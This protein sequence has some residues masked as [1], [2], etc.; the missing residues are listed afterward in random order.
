MWVAWLLWLWV[1]RPNQYFLVSWGRHCRSS[2]AHIELHA[3]VLSF[4]CQGLNRGVCITDYLHGSAR[5][6]D[7]LC[8][9][10]A[11]PSRWNILEVALDFVKTAG[12]R[13][14]RRA[15]TT[16]FVY[17]IKLFI[18]I[19]M[20]VRLY[21]FAIIKLWECSYIV[22]VTVDY[23]ESTGRRFEVTKSTNLIC[24][25]SSSRLEV[26]FRHR[27][28]TIN[29]CW[30]ALSRLELVMFRCHLFSIRCQCFRICAVDVS[31]HCLSSILSMSAVYWNQELHS[32]CPF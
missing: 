1:G 10:T 19:H 16:L 2:S 30:C 3:I 32:I 6:A 5:N 29:S 27:N 9:W 20:A 7:C 18:L 22:D 17:G 28:D 4:R 11:E 14:Y 26:E 15:Y 12:Y 31:V 21:A 8:M 25:T 24:S 23:L 13:V